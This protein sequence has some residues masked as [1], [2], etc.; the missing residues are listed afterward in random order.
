MHPANVYVFPEGLEARLSSANL[1]R[2]YI[3][4]QCADHSRVR[5]VRD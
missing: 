1:D 5:T 3:L 4:I 2:S